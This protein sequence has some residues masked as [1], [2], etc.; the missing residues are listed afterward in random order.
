MQKVAV[1]I[2]FKKANVSCGIIPASEHMN[3]SQNEYIAVKQRKYVL[4][5][6]IYPVRHCR[7]FN[8]RI[9]SQRFPGSSPHIKK[10]G[11]S[12]IL[13]IYLIVIFGGAIPVPK[14]TLS[15]PLELIPDPSCVSSRLPSSSFMPLKSVAHAMRSISEPIALNSESINA[16]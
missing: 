11:S 1:W 13:D 12:C 10:T 3:V 14:C 8:A 7:I 5:F 16:R 6:V 15:A 2:I 9:K 4:D